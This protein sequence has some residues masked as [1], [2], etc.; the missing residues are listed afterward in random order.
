M[1]LKPNLKFLD[2]YPKYPLRF[3]IKRRLEEKYIYKN[4][5]SINVPQKEILNKNLKKWTDE[6]V[7]KINSL[8][9][10]HYKRIFLKKNLNKNNSFSLWQQINLNIFFESLIKINANLKVRSTLNNK[11]L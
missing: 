8:Q 5:N 9:N 2:G 4:K 6:N 11:K 3:I 1:A 7:K 10:G